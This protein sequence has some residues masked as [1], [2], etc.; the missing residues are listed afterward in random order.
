[1]TTARHPGRDRIRL[2]L[3]DL[4]ERF[5]PTAADGLALTYVLHIGDQI[6]MALHVRDGRCLVAAH[7]PGSGA[8]VALRTD[9]ATWLELADGRIDGIAAFLAG[10]LQVE[11]DL[12]LA[13]RFETLFRPAPQAMR[14]IRSQRTRSR[15]VTL[16]A[17]VA[18]SGTPV[19]LLHGLGATKVSFLPTLDGLSD[20]YEV[21]ALDLP[22]CGRSGKPVP[23]GRRYSMPW[24][25]DIIFGYLVANDLRDVHVVG[26]SMG[27]RIALELALSRPRSVR[28]V[29]ALAPAVGFDETRRLAPVLRMLRPQWLGLAPTPVPAGVVERMI[30]ELFHAPELL[31]AQNLDAAAA[32]VRRALKDPGYRL[33]LLASARHLGAER[34]R[35]RRGYW[36]RLAGAIPPSLWVFGAQDPLVGAHYAPRIRE[37]LPAA[38]VQVWE[39]VGHVPQFEVP[40]RTNATLH[41]WLDRIETGR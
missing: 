40:Q 27:A 25:A 28:S 3:M 35:G 22:G 6:P 13:A 9:T 4:V 7:V 36:T 21:H 32:D 16:D 39:G 10:R 5:Q 18:G 8:E 19:V 38:D 12:D 31:P 20:A 17:I 14:T 33:A 29:T 26:N 24:F 23:T 34:S 41:R 37:A 11:G 15:G 30:R 2:S 1:V